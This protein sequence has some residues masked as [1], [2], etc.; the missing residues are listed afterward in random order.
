MLFADAQKSYYTVTYL[1]GS[2]ED[3]P[4]P[5]TS[6]TNNNKGSKSKYNAIVVAAGVGSLTC[7]VYACNPAKTH[8]LVH[9]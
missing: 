8:R 7:L 1:S 2:E 3:S 5:Q 4:A 6:D 9:N